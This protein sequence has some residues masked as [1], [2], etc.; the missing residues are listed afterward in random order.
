MGHIIAQAV[1]ASGAAVDD[2]P[3]LRVFEAEGF[4]LIEIVFLTFAL[5]IRK[6]M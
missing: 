1:A 6:F 4:K 2:F 3:A 5:L